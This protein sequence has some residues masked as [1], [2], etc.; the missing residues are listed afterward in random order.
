MKLAYDG[1][2]WQP[3]VS[4]ECL[5]VS[6]SYHKFPY[7]L[8]RAKGEI[9]LKDNVFQANLLAY[10]GNE[11]VRITG[12]TFH[13]LGRPRGR[14]RRQGAEAIPLD[15]KLFS[16]MPAGLRE[17]MASLNP[18]GF[19]S[20]F[21][22]HVGRDQP[23][24]PWRRQLNL[25]LAQ[26]SLRYKDFP[27][28]LD[29]DRRPHRNGG[30]P[31]DLPPTERRQRGQ[32]GYLQRAAGPAARGQRAAVGLH[33][34]QRSAG[35]RACGAA[36]LHSNMQQVWNDLRL[37]GIVNSGRAGPLPHGAGTA[38]RGVAGGAAPR[39]RGRSSRFISPT[40][41]RNSAACSPI[42]TAT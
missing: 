18:R 39:Q 17:V 41:W 40:A 24:Q 26:C 4:L 13:P 29:R 28:P 22:L 31:L 21:S 15:E 35:G 25:D 6:F 37:R 16:A 11:P 42:R 12:R 23:D 10:S 36:L 30:R 5:N 20:D 2:T 27:Y 34:Q 32:P 8:E 1:R 19:I 33:G 38:Q 14:V 9:S 7:R 3:E